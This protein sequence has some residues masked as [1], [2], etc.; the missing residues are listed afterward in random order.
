MRLS[1]TLIALFAWTTG[2]VA[3]AAALPAFGGAAQTAQ[4][5]AA[6]IGE[7]D[8][9]AMTA[10]KNEAAGEGRDGTVA[11]T[12]DHAAM[13][14]AANEAELTKLLAEMDRAKGNA[15]IAIMANVIKRLVA[16]RQSPGAG[17]SA[18]QTTDN[19]DGTAS[20]H[21]TASHGGMSCPMCAAHKSGGHGA[22]A[23]A[24]DAAAHGGSG[25]AMMNHQQSAP[26]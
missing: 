25:C 13:V 9:A 10:Q 23:G 20:G 16:E 18:G 24:A 22:K 3:S 11:G 1:L 4:T 5:T 17:A 21:G 26:Q 7:H 12:H 6:G 2:A 15:K 14:A 8:H 19:A